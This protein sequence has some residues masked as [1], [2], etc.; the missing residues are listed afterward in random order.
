MTDVEKLEQSDKRKFRKN[1]DE[2]LRPRCVS[3]GQ[4]TGASY[5]W[6]MIFTF[7]TMDDCGGPDGEVFHCDKCTKIHGPATS[8][9]RP[10]NGDMRP[11]Q[12]FSNG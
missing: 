12:G 2:S 11:Y 9:A 4:W 3:C 5:S 1:W 6:A 7:P 10:S 8:N